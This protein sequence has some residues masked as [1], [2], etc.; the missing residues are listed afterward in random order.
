MGEGAGRAGALPAEPDEANEPEAPEAVV[1]VV[2]FDPSNPFDLDPDA[3][4]PATQSRPVYRVAAPAPAAPVVQD[5]DLVDW[6][7]QQRWSEFAQSLAKQARSGRELSAKQVAAGRSMRA[8]CEARAAERAKP[9]PAA[10][11]PRDL[12][13]P[14][15]FR[16]YVVG[17]ATYA[18]VATRSGHP[19]AKR[20]E[21]GRSV[22]AAGAI[23]RIREALA[24]GRARLLT[25]R[26]AVQ[27]GEAWGSCICCGRTL[28]NASSI[29]A[30]IGPVCVGDAVA[31]G[32]EEP[33]DGGGVRP[34][35]LTDHHRTGRRQELSRPRQNF[36]F[37]TF[38]VDLQEI[39][40]REVAEGPI[41]R[42]RH[43]GLPR[44]APAR[45]R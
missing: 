21:A 14:E 36:T 33:G 17:D 7:E 29:E 5:D 42:H 26:E 25:M 27:F 35:H 45:L 22:Y 38:D 8:K 13:E 23:H 24:D 31:A 30:G 2:A 39:R 1:Q 34:G 3:P 20:L 11:A 4:A 43:H 9:A 12:P 10:A 41:E 18:V 32:V 16:I 15:V 40:L 28:T 37:R 44:S 19:Y 6:L